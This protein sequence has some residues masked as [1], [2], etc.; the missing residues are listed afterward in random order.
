MDEVGVT[1]PPAEVVD[2]DAVQEQVTGVGMAERVSRDL[3]S[4]RQLASLHRLVERG[5]NPP[6][7]C[8]AGVRNDALFESLPLRP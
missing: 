7:C 4:C 1:E 5:L 3:P 8:H 2:L 6:G